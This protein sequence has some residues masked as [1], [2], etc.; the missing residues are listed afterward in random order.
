M[1]HDHT[2]ETNMTTTTLDH[3][4]EAPSP[5]L[6]MLL[7]IQ[8]YWSS[9]ICGSAARLGLAEHLRHGPRTIAELA[10]LTLAEPD[11]LGRLLRAGATIGLFTELE[12]GRFELT[13]LGGQLSYG[14][15]AG[16]LGDL[17]VALTSPGHWLPYGRLCEAVLTGSPQAKPALGSDPWAYFADNPEERRHFARAMGAISAEASEAIVRHYDVSRFRRIVDVGGSHGLLLTGLLATAPAGTGVLFDLPAVIAG[18]HE[19][20]AA[21]GQGDRVELVGGDFFEEVPAGGDLYLLKS[22]LHD[23]DDERALRILRNIHRAAAPDAKL[24]VIEGLLPSHPAPSYLHLATCSCS[25][26]WAVENAHSS[27]TPICSPRPDSG[28]S[29]Q[30]PRPHRCLPGP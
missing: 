8:W 29:A 17:A 18:A 23:W 12:D 9:Q 21:T 13:T 11:G 30:S 1:T 28:S 6:Q 16:S 20:L 19:A 15:A 5:R 14:N 10:S 4:L 25:S 22:V 27:S 3:A 7:L 24:A 26:S 2:N